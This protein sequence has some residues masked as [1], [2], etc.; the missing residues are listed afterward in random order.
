MVEKHRLEPRK[1]RDL[2]G[3]LMEEGS[4]EQVTQEYYL[5]TGRLAELE[6]G[7][8]AHLAEHGRLEVKDLKDVYGLSR[9][10]SIP[11]LEYFD[12]VRVTRREGDY[13]VLR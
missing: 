12:R 1:A 6:Q 3:M 2:V 9:K 10:Y 5:S 4:I 13:R 11:L 7:I 8:R